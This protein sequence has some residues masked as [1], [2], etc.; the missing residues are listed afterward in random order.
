MRV[1][2]EVCAY[3]T[4]M[5]RERSEG[6]RSPLRDK[7]GREPESQRPK[8]RRFVLRAYCM[9]TVRMFCRVGIRVCRVMVMVFRKVR[10]KVLKSQF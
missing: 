9:V 4:C 10:V 1:K 5:S 6:R 3:V 8:S 2:G 7:S